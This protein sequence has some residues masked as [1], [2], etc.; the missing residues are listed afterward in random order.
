[1]TVPERLRNFS[2]TD[3]IGLDRQAGEHA[4]GMDRIDEAG[5]RLQ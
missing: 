1:M 4:L 3:A 2:T 5:E